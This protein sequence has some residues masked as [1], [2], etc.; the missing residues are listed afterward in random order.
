MLY[1]IGIVF[2]CV[3]AVVIPSDYDECMTNTS[4]C[5]SVRQACMNTAGSY[6]CITLVFGSAPN[7]E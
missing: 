5:H 7:G 6:F 4:I 3:C 2:K 1:L